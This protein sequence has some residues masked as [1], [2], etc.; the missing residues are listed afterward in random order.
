VAVITLNPQLEGYCAN[1]S[2]TFVLDPPTERQRMLFDAYREMIA[3]TRAAMRP[4]ATVR[5][6]DAV[7]KK[8]LAARGLDEFHIEGI[9]HGIGLRFEETPASTIQKQHRNVEIE[10]GMTLTI[11]HTVLAVPGACGVRCEDI[12][13]VTPDGGDILYDHPWEPEI[14]DD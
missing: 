14:T 13:R 10:E 4:G 8:V 5:D 1:L 12:Y 9:S 7:G 11:G 2:R 6:L 3:A